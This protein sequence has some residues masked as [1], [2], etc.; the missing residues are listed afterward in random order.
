[1][2]NVLNLF[3]NTFVNMQ[4]ILTKIWKAFQKHI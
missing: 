3:S 4:D 1:M 2:K